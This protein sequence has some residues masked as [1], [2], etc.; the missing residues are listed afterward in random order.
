MCIFSTWTQAKAGSF[1]QNIELLNLL[2][3]RGPKAFSTF[4]EALRETKQQHLE[5]MLLSTIPIQS[6]GTIR[7]RKNQDNNYGGPRPGLVSS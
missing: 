4:C 1:S 6:N 5:E 2:P 3:K 7:G